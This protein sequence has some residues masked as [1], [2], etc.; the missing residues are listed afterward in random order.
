MAIGRLQITMES[1]LSFLYESILT[2]ITNTLKQLLESDVSKAMISSLVNAVNTI[3]DDDFP[4]SVHGK[5]SNDQ[6]YIGGLHMK[7]QY[8]EMHTTG[9]LCS[10]QWLE[11]QNIWKCSG[12]NDQIAKPVPTYLTNSDVDYLVSDVVLQSAY[13][14]WFDYLQHNSSAADELNLKMSGPP[15]VLEITRTGVSVLMEF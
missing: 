6:R 10:M 13:N 4:N 11:E 5:Y 14:M 2:L 7:Q 9:Q 3:L 12:W 1:D 15:K 8:F